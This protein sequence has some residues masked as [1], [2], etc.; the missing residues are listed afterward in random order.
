MVNTKFDRKALTEV[1]EVIIMLENKEL[2]K[3]PEKLIETIKLNKDNEYEVDFQK[4]ENGEM[5]PDTMKILAA[6]YTYYLANEEEKNIINKLINSKLEQNQINHPVFKRK[7][8]EIQ[9]NKQ[10]QSITVIKSYNLFTRILNKI[11]SIFWR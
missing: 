8:V 3:I 4:L 10:E 2:N 9:K 11:K 5:L 6:L 1:Y 7:K